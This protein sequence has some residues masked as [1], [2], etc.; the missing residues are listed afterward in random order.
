MILRPWNIHTVY[1]LTDVQNL[2][3]S[4]CAKYAT[5]TSCLKATA[6]FVFIRTFQSLLLPSFK[7]EWHSKWCVRNKAIEPSFDP[8]T[9]PSESLSLASCFE[10]GKSLA[11]DRTNGS[12][13]AA[14]ACSDAAEVAFRRQ[15]K[16]SQLA[17]NPPDSTEPWHKLWSQPGWG[18]G[19][20]NKQQ[21][22][23]VASGV[24]WALP[25]PPVPHLFSYFQTSTTTFHFL[26]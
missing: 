9:P 7:S 15:H 6:G 12:S 14:M 11:A 19:W 8:S 24:G 1:I 25:P 13:S 26:F 21:I 16:S 22:K 2:A 17:R 3:D 20:G 5:C 18:W 4:N 23:E 10:I